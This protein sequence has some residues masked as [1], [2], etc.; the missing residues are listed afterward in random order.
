MS[1]RRRLRWCV[2]GLGFCAVRYWCGLCLN[3]GEASS[4][5][6]TPP[7]N[8]NGLRHPRM[9]GFHS[10]CK[11]QWSTKRVRN[12]WCVSFFQTKRYRR[13][14]SSCI[15]NENFRAF[16]TLKNAGPDFPTILYQNVKVHF[17]FPLHVLSFVA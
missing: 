10:Y 8:N 11:P 5:P 13:E 7:S 17:I 16:R 14:T 6:A 3:H 15:P 9:V 1:E 12:E 2:K 4:R